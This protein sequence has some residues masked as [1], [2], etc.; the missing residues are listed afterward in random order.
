MPRN[1]RTR[2]FIDSRLTTDFFLFTRSQYLINLYIK[3]IIHMN[4]LVIF[5]S[6]YNVQLHAH[7]KILMKWFS[8]K[9]NIFVKRDYR[10]TKKKSSHFKF[11]PLIPLAL[12]ILKLT[13]KENTFDL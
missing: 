13:S 8:L 9:I 5:L 11:K 3:E 2:I 10:Q 1:R 4:K 12:R 6:E 7:T